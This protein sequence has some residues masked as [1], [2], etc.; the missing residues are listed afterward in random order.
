M[1]FCYSN[2]CGGICV[3]ISIAVLWL[4]SNT[5]DII[6]IDFRKSSIWEIDLD[7]RTNDDQISDG[8]T[9]PSP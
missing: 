1:T 8:P 2:I 7:D 4:Y 9:E 5:E 6:D 3:N